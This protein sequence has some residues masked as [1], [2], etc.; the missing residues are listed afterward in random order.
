MKDER[1][2]AKTEA[3]AQ[4]E[5]ADALE[6]GTKTE[7]EQAIAKARTEGGAEAASKLKNGIRRSEVKAA[8]MAAGLSTMLDLAVRA[9]E[10]ASL[11]VDDDGEVAGLS[12]A[13]TAF[14]GMHADLFKA[15]VPPGTADGGPRGGS[16]I[17]VEQ[18]RAW[19]RD[20]AMYELHR[21]E[22]LKAM[23]AKP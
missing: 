7:T 17:T 20:P 10:F 14:K 8:L 16:T 5:R 6:L 12:A 3:K 23:A 13:V 4:K 19:A 1:D 11:E 22:I 15:A 21:D 9:D 2:A 18:A